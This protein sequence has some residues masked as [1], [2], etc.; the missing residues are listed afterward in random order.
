MIMVMARPAALG[1]R[2]MQSS[3]H[4]LKIS[5]PSPDR[6]AGGANQKKDDMIINKPVKGGRKFN[7]MLKGGRAK[8]KRKRLNIIK[9][10][11]LG[12]KNIN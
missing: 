9:V 7:N 4:G 6:I 12:F 10:Y 11:L 1:S 3:K 2:V 5:N 8:T